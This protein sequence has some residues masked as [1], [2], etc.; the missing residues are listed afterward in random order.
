MMLSNFAVP[1]EGRT[2]D[3]HAPLEGWDFLL[4]RLGFLSYLAAGRWGFGKLYI[5]GNLLLG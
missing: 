4:W 5:A 2:E 3:E 1:A